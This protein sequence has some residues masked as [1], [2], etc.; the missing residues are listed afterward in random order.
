MIRKLFAAA[1][2][3]LLMSATVLGQ[4][5]PS[6]TQSDDEIANALIQRSQANYSGNCPCPD[7]RAANGSRCGGRSAYSR[8]GGASPLCYRSDVTPAMIQSERERRT[9]R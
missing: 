5:A 9:R 1:F 2:F 3:T 4:Q 6:A 8:P 7:N